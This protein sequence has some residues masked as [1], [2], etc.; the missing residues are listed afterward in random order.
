MAYGKKRSFME[1]S[2]W[3][4]FVQ[5]TLLTL[6]E[7]FRKSGTKSVLISTP[8]QSSIHFVHLKSSQVT[9]SIQNETP[10]YGL[11]LPKISFGNFPTPLQKLDSIGRKFSR[12]NLFVKC[13]N[14][15][16]NLYGGNKIRKLEYLLA[17]AQ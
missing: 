3:V 1:K 10:K 14:V 7:L 4:S 13:D 12:D 8:K 5:R 6:M 2:I 17:D 15:S 9:M 11:N 16:G